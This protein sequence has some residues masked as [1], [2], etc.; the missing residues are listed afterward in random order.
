MSDVRPVFGLAL[1]ALLAAGPAMPQ[2]SPK[3][4]TAPSQKPPMEALVETDKGSFVIGLLGEVAPRHVAHFIEIAKKG[5]FDGTTFHRIIPGGIVQGGDPLSK[6]PAKKALYGTG[7][8]SARAP[9]LLKAEFSDRPMV[10]GAVAAVLLPGKPDSAGSQFF[11]CLSDQPALTGQYTIFGEVTS[12][13]AV[14]DGIGATPVEGDK[15][16]TRVEMKKVTIREV[17]AAPASSVS[18]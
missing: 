10:R 16:K 11:I 5:G 2:A 8:L 6:D 7:G 3:P 15:A 9:W 14:V 13:M 18:P 4:N 1:L 17:D 12:G